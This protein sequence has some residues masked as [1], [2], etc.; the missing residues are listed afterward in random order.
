M[1]KFFFLLQKIQ[2]K[3]LVFTID[4]FIKRNV[5]GHVDKSDT[6]NNKFYDVKLAK[7]LSVQK[8]ILFDV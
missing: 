2:S 5:Y 6:A 8:K 1:N 7:L 4:I 3:Y